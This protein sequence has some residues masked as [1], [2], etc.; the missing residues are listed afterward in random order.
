MTDEERVLSCQR[1]IRRL[2]SVVRE[3]EEER[4]LFLAWL[5]TESKIPSENQAGLNR[6]KQYLDTYLYQDQKNN[7][8]QEK[9]ESM[10]K[11]Y[12]VIEGNGKIMQR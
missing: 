11:G 7:T 8:I 9:G 3:Y 4:R 2:R 12:F 10:T 6:V 5:E 1:E